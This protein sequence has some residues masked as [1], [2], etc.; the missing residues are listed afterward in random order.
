MGWSSAGEGISA[1]D[2]GR[3]FMAVHFP[4]GQLRILDYN[5][6]VRDLN[7]LDPETFVERLR[8]QGFHVKPNHRA[9]KPSAPETGACLRMK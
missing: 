4:A 5:R 6:V 7:G 1:N 8:Q 3:Y 2:P 9:K